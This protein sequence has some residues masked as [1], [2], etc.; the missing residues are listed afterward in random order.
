V[1]ELEEAGAQASAA[2]DAAM[3][4]VR[5]ALVEKAAQS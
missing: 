5:A 4:E 1:R 3:E 2:L